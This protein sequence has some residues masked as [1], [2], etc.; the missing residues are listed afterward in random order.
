VYFILALMGHICVQTP[1]YRLRAAGKNWQST[2]V[3]NVMLAE[4]KNKLVFFIDT[5]GFN[6]S[7]FEFVESGEIGS[8]PAS[9]TGAVTDSDAYT[10]HLSINKPLQTEKYIQPGRF[11]N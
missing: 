3:N 6:V 8:I 9:F 5:A 7:S 4:G 2:L 10:I 11:F 1:K